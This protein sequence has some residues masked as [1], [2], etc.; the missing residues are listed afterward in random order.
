MKQEAEKKQPFSFELFNSMADENPD[1]DILTAFSFEH[2]YGD[3]L[4]EVVRS[5]Y[6]LSL[7][8]KAKLA[9]SYRMLEHLTRLQLRES[10]PKAEVFEFP[11]SQ[12]RTLQ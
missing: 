4:Q 10:A 1:L 6:E 5:A 12:G 11:D 8:Y 2:L 3:D 7:Y 9:Y